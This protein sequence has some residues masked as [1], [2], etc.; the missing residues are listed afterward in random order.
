MSSSISDTNKERVNAWFAALAAA[1]SL[2]LRELMSEEV[3]LFTAPSVR[4]GAVSGRDA[5]Q[6]RLEQVLSSG[7][8]FAACS[9]RCR[10]LDIVAEGD[11]TAAHVIMSGRFSDGKPYESIYIVWQRWRDGK[12]IYQ[13][14]LFD[15]AH[16]NFQRES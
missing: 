14:E 2:A 8:H 13:L 11:Q 3:E 1:D 16:K 6:S 9:L 10:V 12:L 4:V 5:A 7:S 15:V